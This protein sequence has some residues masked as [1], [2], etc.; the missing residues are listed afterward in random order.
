MS[1]FLTCKATNAIG[2]ILPIMIMI[3]YWSIK[4]LKNV[5]QKN[6]FFGSKF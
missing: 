3:I 1:N 6:I 2:C 5:Y 4:I